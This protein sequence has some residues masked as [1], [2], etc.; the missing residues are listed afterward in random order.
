M[1]GSMP[2]H[3]RASLS[4]FYG[5]VGDRFS[6]SF[7]SIKEP[8][9]GTVRSKSFTCVP[10]GCNKKKQKEGIVNLVTPVE[11]FWQGEVPISRI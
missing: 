6:L 9:L 10:L 4:S 7:P 11:P 5:I 3:G 1:D 2:Y 8:K